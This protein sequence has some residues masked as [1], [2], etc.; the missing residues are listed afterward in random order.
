MMGLMT[1][2]RI[3]RKYIM[4]SGFGLGWWKKKTTI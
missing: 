1:Y 2:F 3:F 4:S